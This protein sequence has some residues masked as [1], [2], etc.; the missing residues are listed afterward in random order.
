MLQKPEI[1]IEFGVASGT[2]N[3]M[4]LFFLPSLFPQKSRYLKYIICKFSFVKIRYSYI[5]MYVYKWVFFLRHRNIPRNMH[6]TNKMSSTGTVYSPGKKRLHRNNR[7]TLERTLE[8]RISTYIFI[9]G[10]DSLFKN[11][12]FL[13]EIFFF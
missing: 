10:S 3:K 5:G 12:L 1:Q 8:F 4:P 2:L 7:H 6:R 13:F 11:T 9:A